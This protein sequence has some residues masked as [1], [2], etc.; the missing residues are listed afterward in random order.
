MIRFDAN[1]RD[2]FEGKLPEQLAYVIEQIPSP[3]ERLRET[4]KRNLAPKDDDAEKR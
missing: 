4:I 2:V 3:K 1:V